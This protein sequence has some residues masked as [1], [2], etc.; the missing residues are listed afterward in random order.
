MAEFDRPWLLFVAALFH[1][2]AKGRGGDHSQ[3]GRI[4]ARRFCREHG[5]ADEDRELVE[6]LV[7][8]H[9]TMSSVAQKQDLSDPET[10]ARFAA[11]VGT[12]RR[13]VAL[14]LLT[15]A[16]IRGTSPK[17]WNAW[18]GKLL[19]DLFR[20]AKRVLGGEAASSDARF[21]ARRAEAVRLLN[22][23][24][25]AP[26]AYAGF[27]R[28]LDIGYFLRNDAQDIAWQTRVLFRHGDTDVPVVR[29]RLAPIGEGFQVVVYLPD[30]PDLFARICGYFDS[31][32]LSVLDAR[33]HTTRNGRALDS[34]LVVDPN[35]Q[36]QY[37]DILSL[38]EAELAERLAQR[39]PLE[40]PVRGR[41]S[42]RS[43]YFP[44]V[45]QVDLRPDE[46]GSRYLLSIVANDR[47]G[48][49]YSIART[50][51]K[52]G[53]NLQAARIMTLGERAEDTFLI[54]GPALSNAR[55]Q[56]QLENELLD[57]LQ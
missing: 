30:Q 43:R 44:I 13:L 39:R 51:A 55:Q 24:G 37:R 16:D 48:L 33:I 34:F 45:P 6:F 28:Q 19:E 11:L 56:I 17:V 21:D 22:L 57:A 27:W 25:L 31:K 14:Y 53:L 20:G 7:E 23:H 12:E 1:D 32:N 41:A 46:R 54:D 47:T 52:H 35:H 4:D 10:I 50:L 5:L 3:L 26:D 40:T 8:H 38:V 18:K 15:V 49:L 42:R 36:A 9:L 2:I 29:T